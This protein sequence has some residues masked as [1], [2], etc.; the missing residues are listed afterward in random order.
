[1]TTFTT[2]YLL[3][4]PGG[5][6]QPDGP[7]QVG[8]LADAVDTLIFNELGAAWS[9][10]TLTITATT[11]NPTQGN[12]VYS[13]RYRMLNDHTVNVVLRVNFGTTFVAGSGTYSLS[14]PVTPA[15]T[16]GYGAVGSAY[17]FNGSVNYQGSCRVLTG[18]LRIL[19]PGQDGT[20]TSGHAISAGEF[21]STFPFTPASGTEFRASIIYEV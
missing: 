13:A 16:E 20:T 18:K 6:D 14:L 10:Y 11:T 2:N 1:M 15:D 3:P 9:T 17:L 5:A 7:T 4:K 19:V 12:S 21:A 8:A